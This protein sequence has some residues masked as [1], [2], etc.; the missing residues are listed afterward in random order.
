LIWLWRDAAWDVPENEV[1]GHR[2][3]V[4]PDDRLVMSSELGFGLDDK[5]YS[6]VEILTGSDVVLA[7]R[8]KFWRLR[9][10]SFHRR[11]AS[12]LQ[13]KG[14]RTPMAE[15]GIVNRRSRKTRSPNSG[16]KSLNSSTKSTSSA[17]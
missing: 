15:Q 17:P 9:A 12:L 10:R 4:R 7:P 16:G 1:T 2:A 8:G 11:F 14:R 3:H 5:G 13:K 6:V